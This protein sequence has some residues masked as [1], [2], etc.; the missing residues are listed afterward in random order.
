[1]PLN[2]EQMIDVAVNQYFIGCNEHKFE[3]IVNTFADDC[4]MWFPAADYKYDGLEP[5]K[6]HFEDF[7]STFQDINFHN[8]INIADE[9]A[10]AI[11][12]YFDIHLG[13]TG[14]PTLKMKNCNI[15]HF[16]EAGQFS[17][18]IIYNSGALSDGFQAGNS[19][20]AEANT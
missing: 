8:F 7:L 5:L 2:R 18:I 1:M 20:A 3:Q 4:V 19:S 17:E 6:V 9:Q 14:K 15:F 16:N 12:T 13:A 10:Q 11:T